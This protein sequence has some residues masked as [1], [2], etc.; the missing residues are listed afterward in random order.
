[1]SNEEVEKFY[2]RWS[3]LYSALFDN[4]PIIKQMRRRSA[5]SL[6]LE[7]GDTVVEIGCG[8][9]ANLRYLREEVG[10][11]GKVIGIDISEGM[12]EKARRKKKRNN[13]ENVELLKHDASKANLDENL[14]GVLFCFSIGMFEKPGEI[15]EKW[16]NKIENGCLTITDASKVEGRFGK[17][18]NYLMKL[19]MVISTPPLFKLR[20]DDSIIEMAERKGQEINK[21]LKNV[22]YEI[23]EEKM[24]KGLIKIRTARID[25]K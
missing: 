2:T 25:T 17:P 7:E 13:W 16:S 19:F 23:K 12:L 15:I 11:E 14:E 9:G 1:M 3:S 8:T 20:F 22:G 10:K 5:M 18:I 24:L 6:E 4:P 21:S